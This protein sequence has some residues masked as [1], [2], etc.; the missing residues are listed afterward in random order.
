MKDPMDHLTAD[1]L[2]QPDAPIEY[3]GE[4]YTLFADHEAEIFMMIENKT[5]V[6]YLFYDEAAR[7]FW[8]RYIKGLHANAYDADITLHYLFEE[9]ENE[10]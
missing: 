9:Y 3:E 10:L 7:E 8:A 1:L 5:D 2:A 4:H 6:S